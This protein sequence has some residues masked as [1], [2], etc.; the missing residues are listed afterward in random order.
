MEELDTDKSGGVDFSEFLQFMTKQENPHFFIC[1]D[2]GELSHLV[3][4]LC[5]NQWLHLTY[6]R[7]NGCSDKKD[8][9][10]EAFEVMDKDGD[11]N[12]SADDLKQVMSQL[13]VNLGK[14]DV[15]EMIKVADKN[16]SGKVNM[17][18]FLSIML[19]D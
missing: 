2:L 11:G 9:F 14:E 18:E 15:E 10:R 5:L 17:E 3:H 12:I 8:E 4:I 19:M 7:E 6:F 13:G 1:S 16:G